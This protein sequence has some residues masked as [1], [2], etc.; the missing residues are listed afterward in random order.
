MVNKRC[1][2]C[3]KILLQLTHFSHQ[4]VWTRPMFLLL[5]CMLLLCILHM[6]AYMQEIII[7]KHILTNEFRVFS[8]LAI[9]FK[10]EPENRAWHAN[11]LA[12]SKIKTFLHRLDKKIKACQEDKSYTTTGQCFEIEVLKWEGGASFSFLKVK[13]TEKSCPVSDTPS[14]S[15]WNARNLKWENFS[16]KL[17]VLR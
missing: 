4:F 3:G 7:A 11:L 17:S 5:E 12:D 13:T 10:P 16:C 2:F 14:L 9:H 15:F 1:N 6:C 8:M